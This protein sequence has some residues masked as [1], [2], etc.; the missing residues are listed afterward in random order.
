MWPSAD[1]LYTQALGFT[2][3][4]PADADFSPFLGAGHAEA[5]ELGA[6]SH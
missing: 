1:G 4:E 6:V 5:G 3:S 2:G